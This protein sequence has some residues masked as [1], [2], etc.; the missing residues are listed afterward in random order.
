MKTFE[1]AIDRKVTVWQREHHSV[2]AD[3]LEEATKLLIETCKDNS[4]HGSTDLPSY[5]EIWETLYDTENRITPEEN[6]GQATI[7]ILNMGDIGTTLWSNSK[8]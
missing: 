4:L 3:S 7:E 8:L 5:T 2:E 1:L 6:N